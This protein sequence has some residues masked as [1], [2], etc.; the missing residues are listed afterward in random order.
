MRLL[1]VSL[2]HPLG[3][4]SSP[5]VILQTFQIFPSFWLF[6]SFSLFLHLFTFS[7]LQIIFIYKIFNSDYFLLFLIRLLLSLFPLSH[8]TCSARGWR[9]RGPSTPPPYLYFFLFHLAYLFIY[10]HKAECIDIQYVLGGVATLPPRL[11]VWLL[12]SHHNWVFCC[13]CIRSWVVLVV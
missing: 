8:L 4:F 11:T 3:R 7:I 10:F 9:S 2:F 1:F 13:V 12:S 5:L 6:F